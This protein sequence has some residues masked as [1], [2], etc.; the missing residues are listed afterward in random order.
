MD[1]IS[2]L[3][4][5]V[6]TGSPLDHTMK[7]KSPLDYIVDTGSPL[8]HTVEMIEIK[9]LCQCIF[10]D[11]GSFVEKYTCVHVFGLAVT[12]LLSVAMF[13]M[14]DVILYIIQLLSIKLCLLARPIWLC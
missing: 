12:A 7:T 1:N 2:P 3:D 4:H 9:M 13:P 11:G 8:D 5:N 10:N 14:P 6:D